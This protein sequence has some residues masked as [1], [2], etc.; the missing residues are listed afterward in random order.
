MSKNKRIKQGCPGIHSGG[1][2]AGAYYEYANKF[3]SIFIEFRRR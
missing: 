2:T 1:G 3:K